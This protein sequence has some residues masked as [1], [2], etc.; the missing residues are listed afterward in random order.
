MRRQT[1]FVARAAM[2]F[3]TL[4]TAWPSAARAT[5]C[6][7][8][9]FDSY[10]A[11]RTVQ[12]LDTTCEAHI[13]YMW[14]RWTGMVEQFDGDN[15]MNV[16]WVW[17]PIES[18]SGE[19]VWWNETGYFPSSQTSTEEFSFNFYPVDMV[20]FDI[21]FFGKDSYGNEDPIVKLSSYQAG[22]PNSMDMYD[23]ALGWTSG[24][25][26]LVNQWNAVAVR[27]D[28][29]SARDDFWVKVNEGPWCGPYSSGESDSIGLSKV[30]F[31]NLNKD[32]SNA[33]AYYDDFVWT[34]PE[35]ATIA[36]LGLG[37]LVLRVRCRR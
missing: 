3:L 25:A 19:V 4:C 7:Q 35:P 5:I 11:G 9:D 17:G 6:W 14:P 34:V 24:G 18:G 36:L 2:V 37:G 33:V 10:E 8:E 27:I 20:E 26:V 28:Y 15:A 1:V 13:W 21:A 30:Q 32:N 31:T 16:S 12:N 23:A 29:G 22:G